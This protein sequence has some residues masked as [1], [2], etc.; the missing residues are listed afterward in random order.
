MAQGGHQGAVQEGEAG[1]E[2]G[3]HQAEFQIHLGQ[4]WSLLGL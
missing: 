4:A 2:G 1:G 3:G